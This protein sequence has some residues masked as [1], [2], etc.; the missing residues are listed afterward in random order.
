[1]FLREQ[2]LIGSIK[3]QAQNWA[4]QLADTPANL[5]TPTIFSKEVCS[6]LTKLGITVQVHDKEW[7]EQ[8]QMGSFLSVSR[9]SC[10]P[11]KFVEIHYKG[12][13]DNSQP[14][15]FVGKGVTFDAGGISLKVNITV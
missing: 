13:N 6:V 3:A 7:A 15:A 12:A 8:K 14:I 9:G 10:E 11:P 4:R 2:W 1:M 5:M